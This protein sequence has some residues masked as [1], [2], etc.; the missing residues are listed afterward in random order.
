M[1]LV[2]LLREPCK[3]EMCKVCLELGLPYGYALSPSIS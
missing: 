2:E 3:E 1:S